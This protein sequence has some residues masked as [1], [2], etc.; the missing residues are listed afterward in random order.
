MFREYQEGVPR[1]Y[2]RP[3]CYSYLHEYPIL[4][5]NRKDSGQIEKVYESRHYFDKKTVDFLFR[6]ENVIII[7]SKQM[8]LTRSSS[9]LLE[10]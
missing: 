3:F 7:S 2:L 9:Q 10:R 1:V 8:I 5:F 6:Y 4:L